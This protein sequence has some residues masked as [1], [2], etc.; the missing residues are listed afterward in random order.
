M[1]SLLDGAFATMGC[2]KLAKHAYDDPA[3]ENTPGLLDLS[4]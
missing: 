4:R 3:I 1:Y 2:L